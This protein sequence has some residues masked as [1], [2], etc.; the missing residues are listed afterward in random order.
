MLKTF[1][2]F[3]RGLKYKI[4]FY[5]NEQNPGEDSSCVRVLCRQ[6]L[7]VLF[8]HTFH[9]CKILSLKYKL[10]Y[11]KWSELSFF[12]RKTHGRKQPRTG[13]WWRWRWPRSSIE[14]SLRCLWVFS[15]AP[16]APPESAWGPFFDPGHRI[17]SLP[18]CSSRAP[19][20]VLG[21]RKNQWGKTSQCAIVC[22]Y[23]AMY[24]LLITFYFQRVSIVLLVLNPVVLLQIHSLLRRVPQAPAKSIQLQKQP[25]QIFITFV[26]AVSLCKWLRV[27]QWFIWPY[28]PA[29]AVTYVFVCDGFCHERNAQDDDTGHHK[30][31][32]G[33]VEVVDSAYDG[34]TVA[35]VYAAA[36][37]VRKLGYHPG[38]ADE[39]A[40]GEAVK[41]TL[42]KERSLDT[43]I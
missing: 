18:S 14:A 36:C 29:A 5:Y 20:Q 40:N 25:N 3:N 26:M 11:S 31:D 13:E 2:L 33:E 12:N 42:R 30:Q 24:C 23:N 19:P 1:W 4:H 38:Q 10:P 7:S 27:N 41:R 8:N 6:I 37:A 39:Q 16:P 21:W 17:T 15:A 32:D 43:W 34:G 35:G 28:L 9:S 22:T